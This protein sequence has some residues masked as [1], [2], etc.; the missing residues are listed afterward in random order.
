M[1]AFADRSGAVGAVGYA[2]ALTVVSN[3]DSGSGAVEAP[4]GERQRA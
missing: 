3:A 1:S 2:E 4:F